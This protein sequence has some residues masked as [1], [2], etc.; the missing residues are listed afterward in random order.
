M[1]S[2]QIV[3]E[4][5]IAAVH[6]CKTLEAKLN[7][8]RPDVAANADYVEAQMKGQLA[9]VELLSELLLGMEDTDDDSSS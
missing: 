9:R 4:R 6:I 3:L 8:L 7:A 2:R 5:L 1:A